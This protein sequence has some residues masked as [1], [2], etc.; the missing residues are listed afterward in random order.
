[1]SAMD[2]RFN[3]GGPGAGGAWSSAD[4]E[5]V[6]RAAADEAAHPASGGAAFDPSLAE[7]MPAEIELDEEGVA[8][9]CAID[10]GQLAAEAEAEVERYKD[11]A[12]RAQAELDNYR[13]RV[14]RE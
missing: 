11:A 1:M 14:R 10:A 5:A 7:D 13:K 3:T 6:R 8:D 12:L 4:D 2:D 9:A